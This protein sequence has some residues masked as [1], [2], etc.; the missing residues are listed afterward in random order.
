[1][2]KKSGFWIFLLMICLITISCHNDFDDNV[3]M[4]DDF[5]NEIQH[6]ISTV[7]SQ[8][9]SDKYLFKVILEK[10]KKENELIVAICPFEKQML[11]SADTNFFGA[12]TIDGFYLLFYGY[13]EPEILSVTDK[14]RYRKSLFNLSEDY[15]MEYD[16]LCD[17]FTFDLNGDTN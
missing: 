13:P 7:S 1:M 11:S 16:P 6:R 5:K 14:K 15:I 10:S 12:T 3:V 4:K 2:K 8:L 9:S 17:V